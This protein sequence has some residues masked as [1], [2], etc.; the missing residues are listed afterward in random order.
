MTPQKLRSVP[1]GIALDC[2]TDLILCSDYLGSIRYANKAACQIL[3][4]SSEEFLHLTLEDL[5]RPFEINAM[6]GQYYDLGRSEPAKVNSNYLAR[7]GRRVPVEVFFTPF[8]DEGEELYWINARD[9]SLRIEAEE[10]LREG[11]EKFRGAFEDVAVGMAIFSPDGRF[12][13]VNGYVCNLLG[14]TEEELQAKTYLDITHPDD[15]EKSLRTDQ[16]IISGEEDSTWLEKRYLTKDGRTVWIMLSSSLIRDTQGEPK[17]FVSHIQDITDQKRVEGELLESREMFRSAFEDAAVGM[18][19]FRP[20][21][22][23]QEANTFFRRILGYSEAEIKKFHYLDI[24]H[25]D[26]A[27]HSVEFDRRI[28]TGEIPFAS[29]EKRYLR[30]DGTPVW[31]LVSNSL[32]HDTQGE[33]LYFIAHLQDITGSKEAEQALQVSERRFS[34]FMDNMPGE[35]FIKD[36]EGRYVYC[37]TFFERQANP[38]QPQKIVGR[39]DAQIYPEEYAAKFEENDRLVLESGKAKEFVEQTPAES[40]PRQWLC[41][42]FPIPQDDGTTLIGGVAID[43]TARLKFQKQLEAKEGQLEIQAEQ[44]EKVNNALKVLV[45]H[46]EQEK[47][48]QE[49]SMLATLEKLVA[50]NIREA[51]AT[52]S[53]DRQATLL[54]IALSNLKEVSTPF[55]ERLTTLESKLSPAELKVADLLRHGQTSDEIAEVLS[56]SPH[57]VARHRKSIRRKLGLTNQKVNLRTHL[58]SV[59]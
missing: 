37:N 27:D 11:E 28:L 41:C 17:Y 42:R 32:V 10:V 31:I 49:R 25:P 57:T 40:E 4:Y 53:P 52:R 59:K 9:L 39:T 15:K 43:V 56:I 7:D 24:T 29:Y 48:D 50:V 3:G 23:F 47:L 16:R 58:Q 51:L 45:E 2:S 14:Y 55:A 6:V 46:R 44:L 34:L 19:I 33:P 54:E 36:S 21:G 8:K 1:A 30:K 38:D 12:L 18:A 35:A 20:D 22:H 13:E 5:G 26:D